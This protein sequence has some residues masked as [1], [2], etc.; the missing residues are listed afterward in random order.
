MSQSLINDLSDRVS[1]LTATVARLT[2]LW[3]TSRL[4]AN[5]AET[6]LR[7]LK[8]LDNVRRAALAGAV[9]AHMEQSKT[10]TTTRSLL[11]SAKRAW[12][13]AEAER[14]A[15]ADAFRDHLEA[16]SRMSNTEAALHVQG[17]IDNARNSFRANR[18]K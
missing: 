11:D 10:L 15:L 4:A 2:R 9:A 8:Q 7:A 12:A 6:D 18:E 1:S 14:I 16:D 5:R 13:E 3:E 17:I